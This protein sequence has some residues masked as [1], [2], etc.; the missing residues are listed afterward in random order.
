M[1]YDSDDASLIRV[2]RR[3]WEKARRVPSELQVEMTRAAARGHQAWV[4]AA[5]TTTSRR[6]CR[7]CAERGAQA[8]LCRVLRVGDSPYTALL[9]DY[10]PGMTTTDVREVFAVLRPALDRA[11]RTRH[12]R[13]M[14]RSSR[15][16]FPTEGQRAFASRVARDDR[17]RRGRVAARSDRPSVLHLLLEPRRAADDTLQPGRSGIG[18]VDDARGGPRSLRA[19]DRRLADAHAAQRRT[20]ARSQRVAEPDLGEPRRPQPRVLDALVCAA[21][22]DVPRPAR[23]CRARRVRAR[24]Q[25][26]RARADPASTPTRRRTGSTSSC[27]SSSSSS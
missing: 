19:R 9:D 12:P 21:A 20:V 1:P 24:D 2:T 3:D 23:R 18:L 16:S 17:L 14:R 15:G 10:E 11:R 13:S 5:R 26:R 7:T 22:G 4:E 8:P 6:S 25:P 27:A